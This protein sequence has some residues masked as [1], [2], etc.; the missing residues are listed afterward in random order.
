VS[1]L[2]YFFIEAIDHNMIEVVKDWQTLYDDDEVYL[3]M[4]SAWG[5]GL[6][7]GGTALIADFIKTA[8]YAAV[9][10]GAGLTVI[11]PKR[12]EVTAWT[13]MAVVA[14]SKAPC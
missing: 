10:K 4:L 12:Q 3:F 14:A 6:K 8:D 5:R 9:F 11:G 2:R 7:P 1:V 13:V